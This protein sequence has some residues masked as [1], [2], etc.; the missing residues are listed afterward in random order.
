MVVEEQV[1]GDVVAEELGEEEDVLMEPMS[2]DAVVELETGEKMTQARLQMVTAHQAPR[3][4]K[5][6]I[7]PDGESGSAG[8]PCFGNGTM[9][10]LA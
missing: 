6:I 9:Q 3:E 7:T 2:W 5:M 10:L 8:R 4:P 1:S